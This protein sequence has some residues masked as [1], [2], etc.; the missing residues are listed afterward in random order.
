MVVKGAPFQ[1]TVAPETKPDPLTVRANAAPPAVAEDGLRLVIVNG[2]ETRF[3]RI[4]P[5]RTIVAPD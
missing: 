2:C 1:Y 4:D 5:E 3:A